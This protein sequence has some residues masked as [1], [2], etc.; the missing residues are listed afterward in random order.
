M[1][2][3][4]PKASWMTTTPGHGAW[5]AGGLASKAGMS[6]R[7]KSG[8]GFDQHLQGSGGREVL[9]RVAR[10]LERER[11]GD[12]RLGLDLA[13]GDQPDG[14]LP[15]AD[16]PEH[17]DQVDVAHDEPVEVERHRRRAREAEA[18]DR[19]AGAHRVERGA[20]RLRPAGAE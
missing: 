17:A 8:M 10:A 15:V 9:E 7:R 13:A 14:A 16:R 3:L 2:S 18:D 12:E 4:S 11:A 6:P 5:L 19:A 1:S 20:D